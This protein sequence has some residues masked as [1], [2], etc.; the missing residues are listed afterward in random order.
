MDATARVLGAARGNGVTVA[1]IVDESGVGRNTFYEHFESAA[2]AVQATTREMAEAAMGA[3][4]EGAR[5]A[6]TPRERLRAIAWGWLTS[7]VVKQLAATAEPDAN[8]RAA[9]MASL[10]EELRSALELARRA[11]S[12]GLPTEALRLECV[13]G[14]FVAAARYVGEHPVT[15]VRVACEALTDVTLRIFR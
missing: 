4:R 12:I 3:L 10:D 13:L 11:G 7:P 9:L 8:G 1:A 6:R 14:A 15:D 2:A 5:V